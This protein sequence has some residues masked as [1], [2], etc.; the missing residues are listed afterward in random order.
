[1]KR[2]GMKISLAVKMILGVFMLTVI[3]SAISLMVGSALHRLIVLTKYENETSH[4]SST[5]RTLLE[6]MSGEM[7]FEREAETYRNVPADLKQRLFDEHIKVVEALRSEDDQLRKEAD[8]NYE[9]VFK[10]YAQYFKKI[11]DDEYNDVRSLLFRMAEV[12]DV[13]RIMVVTVEEEQ[14]RILKIFDTFDQ[15]RDHMSG[16][17]DYVDNFDDFRRFVESGSE[18]D[19]FISFGD[20]ADRG[21]FYACVTPYLSEETGEIIGYV[22]VFEL[23]NEAFQDQHN[24]VL[25]YLL[26]IGIAALILSGAAF[27]TTTRFVAGPIREMSEAAKK[28]SSEEG[29]Q[30]KHYFANLNIKTG[31]EIESLS[32]A[33][34]KM[35]SEL[36]EYISE[37]TVMTADKER[38]R[39]EISVAARIQ[40]DM[41]PRS[42]PE[43][44]EFE[45]CASMEPAREVGGDL[46]DFYLIDDDHLALTIA[47]VSDKGIPASL[48]MAVSKT[49]LKNRTLLGGTPAEILTD[50]NVQLCEGNETMQFITVWLG[51]LTISTGELICANGGHENPGMRLGKAPFEMIRTKH[52]PVLGAIPDIVYRDEKYQLSPGD[53]VFVYTDGVTEA[54]AAD[55]ALFTEDRLESVLRSTV[56]EDEP[57]DILQKVH[58]AVDDFVGDAPQFDDLTMLCMVYRGP[59]KE[60]PGKEEPGKE[61]LK[62]EADG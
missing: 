17:F 12:N 53:V 58:N 24:F 13:Y 9:K 50:A 5:V 59:G 45:L 32:E 57:S 27:Y 6:H 52:S 19:Y 10:E 3:L 29:K 38:I 55:K 33:M 15:T 34:K 4:M 2:H 51:I 48:F 43:R 26:A 36:N 42:Y 30:D 60:E 56:P 18:D 47:D 39:T 40:Q 35:E 54:T 16:A 61:C 44:R 20:P 41:L 22:E 46:Y 1:M 25:N 21:T 23:W 7:F 37:L 14:G 28:F 8:E 62:K 11:H 49:I 31:D